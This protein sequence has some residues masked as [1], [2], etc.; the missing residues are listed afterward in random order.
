MAKQTKGK[1]TTNK[2]TLKRRSARRSA[3]LRTKAERAF[4]GGSRKTERELHQVVPRTTR[5]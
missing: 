5:S 2:T 1:R 3:P 4:P